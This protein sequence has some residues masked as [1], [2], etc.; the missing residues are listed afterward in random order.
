MKVLKNKIR[1]RQ[2]QREKV[3]KSLEVGNQRSSNESSSA[4]VNNDWK[5]W[6]VL[7]G[8]E[9]VVADDIWGIGKVLATIII[10]LVCCL[11]RSRLTKGQFW[12]RR[13][14]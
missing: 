4:S 11:V 12:C 14:L 13:R 6:V 8:K 3:T 9:E 10:C 1:K 5:N 2:R 7:R